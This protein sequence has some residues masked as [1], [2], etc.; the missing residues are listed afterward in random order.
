M[1]KKEKEQTNRLIIQVS[2]VT[3]RRCCVAVLYLNP[4]P[5]KN[6]QK[7]NCADPVSDDP[8]TQ[9]L[10]QLPVCTQGLNACLEQKN[11]VICTQRTRKKRSLNDTEPNPLKLMKNQSHTSVRLIECCNSDEKFSE[12]QRMQCDNGLS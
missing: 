5:A 7:S 12:I 2:V 1:K 6:Q 9:K 4:L 8:L 10:Y 3:C 11:D